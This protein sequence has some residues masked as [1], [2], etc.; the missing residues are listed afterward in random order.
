ME[1]FITIGKAGLVLF[2]LYSLSSTLISERG[3]YHFIWSVWRRFRVTMFLEC[4]VL[5]VLLV[6]AV[7]LLLQVP[8]LK[9]GWTSLFYNGEAGN[10][11]FAPIAAGRESSNPYV[12]FLVP[13]FLVFLIVTFPFLA[14]FEEKTFRK[15]YNTWGQITKKSIEFGLIHC[16]AGIPIGAGIALIIPGF[17]FA[18]KYKQA[19]DRNPE[20]FSFYWEKENEAVMVATTYHTL[21]NTIMVLLLIYFTFPVI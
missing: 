14:H 9:F 3:N 6:T 20:S 2:T 7:V 4:L 19:L 10:I 12:R 18:F 5:A 13:S 1:T 17:F 16:V 21:Y 11:L 15:G 8:F